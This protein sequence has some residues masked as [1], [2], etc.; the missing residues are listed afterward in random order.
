MTLTPRLGTR[1]FLAV[2]TPEIIDQTGQLFGIRSQWLEGVDD[3]IYEYLNTCKEPQELLSH[4]AR[5]RH[6]PGERWRFPLRVLTTTKHLSRNTEGHQILTPILVEPIAELGDEVIY[7]YHVYRDGYD[8]NHE[9]CRL[10]LK[11]VARILFYHLG[12]PIPLFQITEAEMDEVLEGRMIPRGLL[13]GALVTTPSLEDYALSS[14]ESGVAREIEELPDVLQ[15]IAE[16]NLQDFSFDVVDIEGFE[17]RDDE[18]ADVLKARNESVP[19]K[20]QRS[21]SS[22][23][24][25]PVRNVAQALW[26]QDDTLSIAGAVSKIKQMRNLKASAFTES[27]I[28]KRIADLAPEGIRNKPGR[29]PKQSSSLIS[30]LVQQQLDK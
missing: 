3:Q 18:A 12:T 4:I 10:E 7:R 22:A 17:P 26:A 11:A 2:L 13:R 21:S 5:L 1:S 24:W 19:N 29:K 27:A 28:R 9:P 23:S 8:W 30:A 15:Y 6:H 16:H 25:E 20:K 14:E